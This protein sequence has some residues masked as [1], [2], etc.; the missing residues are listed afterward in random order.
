[1]PTRRPG[2]GG[3]TLRF[4]RC[5]LVFGTSLT[6]H[7]RFAGTKPS[8]C[9]AVVAHVLWEHE[10][11]GSNPTAPTSL[12]TRD[13]QRRSTDVP[14]EPGAAPGR[15]VRPQRPAL[16]DASGQTSSVRHSASSTPL[17]GPMK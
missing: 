9:G 6:K 15:A 13:A 14:C 8:G 17:P 10:V 2:E 7:M 11:V 16:S 4:E 3:S 12:L 1:M 5:R